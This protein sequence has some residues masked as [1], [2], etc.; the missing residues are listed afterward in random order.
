MLLIHGDKCLRPSWAVEAEECAR[1]M[2]CCRE[3]LYQQEDKSGCV[4]K[5]CS[6][7]HMVASGAG[8]GCLNHSNVQWVDENHVIF[9][10]VQSACYIYLSQEN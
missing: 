1:Y 2:Y 8:V 4:Y 3:A 5:D 6:C 7:S 9:P 10:T